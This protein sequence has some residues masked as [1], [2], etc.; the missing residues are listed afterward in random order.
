[1]SSA[2]S[3]GS[4]GQSS[5]VLDASIP[6]NKK[7]LTRFL[8][9]KAKKSRIN[10]LVDTNSTLILKS[11]RIFKDKYGYASGSSSFT[12]IGEK[13]STLALEY[14]KSSVETLIRKAKKESLNNQN[15]LYSIYQLAYKQLSIYEKR[16][17]NVTI[18]SIR[19][20][21]KETINKELVSLLSSFES[22]H[23]VNTKKWGTLGST[24]NH[25]VGALSRYLN[26]FIRVKTKEYIVVDNI[27]FGQFYL[28][29]SINN[30]SVFLAIP[31]NPPQD[32][33]IF[34]PNVQRSGN[35]CLGEGAAAINASF[36][37]FYLTE[38]FLML[39]SILRT[40]SRLQ[41]FQRISD[42]RKTVTKCY[43]CG[44]K[45]KLSEKRKCNACSHDYCAVHYSKCS[46]CLKPRC[47]SCLVE[48]SFLS[49]RNKLNAI[50]C[51]TCASKIPKRRIISKTT[52][53]GE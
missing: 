27:D 20:L 38:G 17:I 30:P 16:R 50:V 13:I 14:P 12:K 18:D 4:P 29:C 45:Q 47:F 25:H 10:E 35:I 44:I 52:F 8:S 31:L 28:Y 21:N 1:M 39:E 2:L 23:Y 33:H 6:E 40:R 46:K 24:A 42:W 51:K 22:V 53:T 9:E 7:F 41:P 43:D 11:K 36:R 34:H 26:R 32:G 48:L 37:N 3:I 15:N 19:T 49:R 5:V